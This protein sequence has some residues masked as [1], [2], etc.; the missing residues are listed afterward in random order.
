M[1]ADDAVSHYTQLAAE[2]RLQ[3]GADEPRWL[4]ER[5]ASALASFTAGGFPTRK[6]EGWRYTSLDKLLTQT[7][8]TPREPAYRISQK[9]ISSLRT[10]D[11]EAVRLVFC[12]GHLVEPLSDINNL[13]DGIQISSLRDRLTSPSKQVSEQLDRLFE[14]DYEGFDYI[15][16]T[17]AKDGLW[18]EVEAN[19]SLER[20]IEVIHTSQQRDMG[21]LLV[22]RNLVILHPGAQATLIEHYSSPPGSTDFTNSV[23]QISLGADAKLEHYRLQNEGM[24]TF[25]KSK[26][27]I[28]QAGNS[29]Y[30]GIA[31]NLGASWARTDYRVR[32]EGEQSSCRLN[33]L[34]ITSDQ[35]LSDFHLDV[36]HAVPGCHSD[37]YF[38]GI[39]LGASRAVFDG[40]V[41]VAP[42]AQKTEAHLKNDN[43]LLSRNAEIDTKPVLEIFADDV[44]CS[45]GTT[46]GQLDDEQLFYLRSRGIDEQHARSMLCHGFAR[47]VLAGCSVSGFIDY[48]SNA[49]ESRI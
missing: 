12:D 27:N 3:R 36:D 45:H 30:R 14:N 18:L 9:S 5:R 4:E 24:Q 40:R 16:T 42:D 22:P 47:E 17:L 11:A 33:G 46:V 2:T 19:V 38:K 10:T 32:L 39:L 8:A 37:E 25:H 43:L 7:F 1:N 21:L 48:V 41:R 35:Q 49:I 28:R 29:R 6:Q 23:T 13:P 15:N 20:P 26:L 31:V 34:Y 44:Q